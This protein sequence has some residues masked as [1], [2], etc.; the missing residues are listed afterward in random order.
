MTQTYSDWLHADKQQKWITRIDKDE[1]TPTKVYFEII[2]NNIKDEDVVKKFNLRK[3]INV[4]LTGFDTQ[5]KIKTYK[6][7]QEVLDEWRTARLALYEKRRLAVVQQCDE[8]IQLCSEKI[9]FIKC[10]QNGT[11]K[12]QLMTKNDVIGFLVKRNVKN[13]DKLV[14]MPIFS[15]TSDAMKKL[16]GQKDEWQ[17]MRQTYVKMDKKE[18]WFRDLRELKNKLL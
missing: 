8:N 2:V 4:I 18:L 12:M 16:N 11:I 5:G 13:I 9:D 14:N 3:K 15:M 1:S 7:I 10:V 17:T 6:N